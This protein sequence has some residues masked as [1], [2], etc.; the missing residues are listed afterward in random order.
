MKE[1]AY[2][3]VPYSHPAQSMMDARFDRVNQCAAQLIRRGEVI[4]SPISGNHPIKMCCDNLP[5]DWQFWEAFDTAFLL[6][7]AKL[8]VLMLPGWR[9]SVGV[10]AEI[11]IAEG[12]GI[13]VEYISEETLANWERSC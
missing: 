1:I 7:C 13:P 5:N 11:R 3:A 12:M 8:Y 10:T 2:L 9:E 4:Y 6:R